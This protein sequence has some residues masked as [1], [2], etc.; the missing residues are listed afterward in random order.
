MIFKIAQNNPPKS[1]DQIIF[2]TQK[3][4]SKIIFGKG[5]PSLKALI[6]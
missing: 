3:I 6:F 5:F 2:K 4:K 1:F